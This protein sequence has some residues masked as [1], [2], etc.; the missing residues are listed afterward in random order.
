LGQLSPGA[1]LVLADPSFAEERDREA[2]R[3][4]LRKGGRVLGTG[5]GLVAIVKGAHTVVRT[6]HFEWKSY[7]P[8]EPSALTRGIREIVMAP[9]FLFAAEDGDDAPFKDGDEV[10]VV[11]FSYGKGEVIWWST[12]EPL[13][14][15]GIREKD[16]AQLLLNSIGSPGAPVFWDEYFHQENKTVIDSIW[17]SPLRWGLLDCALM[18]VILCLTWSRRF[19][20]MRTTVE[21]SRLAPIDFVTTLANLY[22]RAKAGNIAIE[23]VSERFRYALHRRYSIPRSLESALLAPQISGLLPASD[24]G[25]LQGLLE[26]VE[27]AVRDPNTKANT[28]AELVRKLHEIADKLRLR[29]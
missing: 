24:A 25:Q 29:I 1:V 12:S 7:R 2:V 4:F 11:R 8:A 26:A 23:I 20:P 9:Q 19:G 22:K 28:A 27:D 6:P 13:S 18:V 5:P 14:N 15:S 16:N 21:H 10:P 17:N 3:E